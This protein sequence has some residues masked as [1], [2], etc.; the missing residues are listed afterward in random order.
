MRLCKIPNKEYSGNIRQFRMEG[1]LDCSWVSQT[2]GYHGPPL[3]K[4]WETEKDAND[5]ARIGVQN[6]DYSVFE[7]RQKG[8]QFQERAKRLKLQQFICKSAS[9]YFSRSFLS[10][11][12]GPED[13]QTI[14]KGRRT[15]AIESRSG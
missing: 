13:V 7:E 8:F 10:E 2:L 1:E 3:Q 14:D 12:P 11:C 6:I 15:F 5:L 9:V 4:I